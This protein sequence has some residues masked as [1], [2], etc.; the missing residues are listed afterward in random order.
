[1]YATHNIEN[2]ETL[3]RKL[4]MDLYNALK[5]AECNNL[6]PYKVMDDMLC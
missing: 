1:M 4:Y 3:L 2:F 6:N 5:T